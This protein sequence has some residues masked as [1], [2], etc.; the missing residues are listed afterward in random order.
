MY[1]CDWFKVYDIIEA[2]H[3]NFA[4]NDENSGQQDAA[5]FAEAINGFF[6]EEGIGWQLVDGQI[7]T[8]GTEAFESVVKDATAA[9][10]ATARP[11]AARHLHEAL[12]DLSRR[13]QPDLA[14]LC[15]T[16]WERLSVL[17]VM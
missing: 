13:L 15:I 2:L 5:L 16:Q 10:E 6:V 9:L 3:A 12:Q 7:V 14:V 8:R 17:P 11:T 4:R 1:G